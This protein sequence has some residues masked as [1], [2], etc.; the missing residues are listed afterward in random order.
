MRFIEI[1]LHIL[2]ILS[3]DDTVIYSLLGADPPFLWPCRT[4]ASIRSSPF[5]GQAF[6]WIR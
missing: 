6:W 5:P 3:L 2:L 1:F 4:A